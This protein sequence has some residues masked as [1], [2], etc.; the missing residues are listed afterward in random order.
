[1]GKRTGMDAELRSILE[2][3]ELEYGA[4]RLE[5]VG[6]VTKDGLKRLWLEGDDLFGKEGYCRGTLEEFR[7]VLAKYRV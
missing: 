5:N 7:R 2:E 3:H 1:M 4:T 6:I